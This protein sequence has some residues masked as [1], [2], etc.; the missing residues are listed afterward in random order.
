MVDLS[1]ELPADAYLRGWNLHE[2]RFA[3]DPII[4]YDSNWRMLYAW[5]YVPSLTEL[6]EICGSL[7]ICPG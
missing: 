5:L 2:Y 3:K 6:F 1:H 4:L 7:I